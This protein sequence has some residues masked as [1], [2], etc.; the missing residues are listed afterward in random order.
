MHVCRR[1]TVV[2]LVERIGD[3]DRQSIDASGSVRQELETPR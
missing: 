2:S 1:H 3:G